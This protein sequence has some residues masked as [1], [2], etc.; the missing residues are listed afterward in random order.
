MEAVSE[1][2]KGGQR[3]ISAWQPGRRG[4]GTRRRAC[5][6]QGLAHGPR[7]P[8]R[9]WRPQKCSAVRGLGWCPSRGV[10]SKPLSPADRGPDGLPPGAEQSRRTGATHTLLTPLSKHESVRA[11]LFREHAHP[12]AR[13]GMCS[14]P[15]RA[16]ATGLLPRGLRAG[17]ARPRSRL[18]SDRGPGRLRRFGRRPAAWNGRASLGAPAGSWGAGDRPPRRQPTRCRP[19]GGG[20]ER[21]PE[22]QVSGWQVPQ[23]PPPPYSRGDLV[24]SQE[25]PG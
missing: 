25:I 11:A 14:R 1:R 19:S 3:S 2:S 6:R 17:L 20:L 18:H 5:R 4:A 21:Y 9:S 8:C 23:C 24:W 16:A 10:S 13:H 15:P 12:H 22:W 7:G